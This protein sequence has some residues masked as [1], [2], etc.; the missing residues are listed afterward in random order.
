MVFGSFYPFMRNHNG[1]FEI[2]QDPAEWSPDHHEKI[3]ISLRLR[4]S[5]LPEL[6]HLFYQSHIE[7]GTVIKSMAEVFYTDAGSRDISDQF[8]WGESILVAP[9]I[10][11]GPEFKRKVYLPEDF[12]ELESGTL[13]QK[14]TIDVDQLIPLYLRPNSI[15]LRQLEVAQTITETRKSPFSVFVGLTQDGE[16]TKTLYWDDDN[17]GDF[18]E[19]HYLLNVKI[20]KSDNDWNFDF[21]AE[22]MGDF[23][24]PSVDQITVYF[25][26]EKPQNLVA[27][28]ENGGSEIVDVTETETGFTI[29]GLVAASK[30]LGLDSTWH[31][32]SISTFDSATN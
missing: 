17:N 9:V 15:I 4:Y 25:T 28:S 1:K 27:H 20:S 18:L 12:F 5:L 3:K 22:K 10:T 30:K 6:H 29:T 26:G 11:E 14:G 13:V 24:V 2:D 16:I 21:S 32:L 7:G 19:N 23:S 31:R 8:L